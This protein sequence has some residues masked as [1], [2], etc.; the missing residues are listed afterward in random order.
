[1]PTSKS[2]N[3]HT[4]INKKSF[5]I[6]TSKSFNFQ[7]RINRKNFGIPTSK[8]SNFQT[9]INKKSFS[10]VCVREDIAR[11]HKMG[12]ETIL[13]NF[14]ART[15]KPAAPGKHGDAYDRVARFFLGTKYQNGIK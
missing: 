1:M 10:Q 11:A 8:S 3:F 6:P 14:A 7:T 4:P 5:G 9:P 12:V 15:N 13:M 2:S